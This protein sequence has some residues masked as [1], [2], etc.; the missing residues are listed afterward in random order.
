MARADLS[1]CGRAGE[2]VRLVVEPRAT[3]R[4]RETV[5]RWLVTGFELT[6]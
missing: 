6:N 3:V 1:A 4:G 2:T 5:E